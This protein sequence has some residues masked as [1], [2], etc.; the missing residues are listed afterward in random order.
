MRSSAIASRRR[1][2]PLPRP[3]KTVAT[4]RSRPTQ[5]TGGTRMHGTFSASSCRW[6]SSSWPLVIFA[7]R[8]ALSE[9]NVAIFRSR[10]TRSAERANSRVPAVNKPLRFPSSR[11]AEMN[12]NPIL[13]SARERPVGRRGL[14]ATHGACRAAAPRS[15]CLPRTGSAALRFREALAYHAA[16]LPQDETACSGPA[17]RQPATRRRHRTRRDP[18]KRACA[19][20]RSAQ[21]YSKY[22]A[23]QIEANAMANRANA[24]VR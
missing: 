6:G 12:N 2:C 11:I 9:G 23:M 1:A 4:F 13:A 10:P 22:V 24:I 5:R 21:R 15:A 16:G 19:A 8:P 18:R 7:R 14:F 20:A 3:A 17:M